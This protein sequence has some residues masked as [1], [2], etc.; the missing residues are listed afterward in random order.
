MT[1][2]YESTEIR[3]RQIADA[4][5]KVIIKYGS[6]HV[7]VKR[8]AKEV[9]ITETAIYRHFRS[10]KDVLSLLVDHIKEN[11]ISEITEA[12]ATD[13]SPLQRLDSILKSHLSVSEQKSGISFQVIA[14]IESLGDKKLNKSV[15]LVIG[16]YVNRIEYLLAEGVKFGE[17]RTDIDLKAAATVVFGIIQGLVSIWALGDYKFDPLIRYTAL[18]DIFLEAVGRRK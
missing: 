1:R 9:G 2:H 11:L 5:R 14:E 13:Q 10:K 3:R 15:S 6:E 8:I 16:E 18:W 4:A 12:E 17:V 7:T